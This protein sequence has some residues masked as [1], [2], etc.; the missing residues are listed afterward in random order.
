[1]Q[2]N[3]QNLEIDQQHPRDMGKLLWDKHRKEEVLIIKNQS[4]EENSADNVI[5]L[6]KS[7]QKYQII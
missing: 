6:M 3:Q 4:R 5:T 2:Y 7:S 1:M